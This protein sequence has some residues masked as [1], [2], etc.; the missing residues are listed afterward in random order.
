M[1]LDLN[2][3]IAELRAAAQV[4][5]DAY[6]QATEPADL[7]GARAKYDTMSDRGLEFA[8]LVKSHGDLRGNREYAGPP[9][10]DDERAVAERLRES[11]DRIV[12]LMDTIDQVVG[13][14]RADVSIAYDIM[15]APPVTGTPPLI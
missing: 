7:A 12:A 14:I 6:L 3:S 10:S 11:A 13:E 4:R 1:A 9:V 8:R 5:G 2:T 15:D